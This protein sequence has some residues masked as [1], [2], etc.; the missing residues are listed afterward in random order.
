MD[1]TANDTDELSGLSVRKTNT[2]YQRI[3]VFM[4]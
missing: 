1:L 4:S 2:I 3:R